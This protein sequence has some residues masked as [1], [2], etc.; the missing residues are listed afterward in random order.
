MNHILDVD[1]P[2]FDGAGRY[3]PNFLV[4]LGEIATEVRLKESEATDLDRKMALNMMEIGRLLA[5]ALD[6]FNLYNEKQM[7]EGEPKGFEE[8]LKREFKQDRSYAYKYIKFYTKYRGDVELV[9]HGPGKKALFA[10][11]ADD[12]SDEVKR[13]VADK[14]AAGVQVKASDITNLKR[15]EKGLPPTW[16]MPDGVKDDISMAYEVIMGIGDLSINPGTV[17]KRYGFANPTNKLEEFERRTWKKA[18]KRLRRVAK[19]L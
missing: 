5:K 18:I 8:W 3:P 1:R 11:A 9:P 19:V 10:L 2:K 7:G 4:E 13:D 12:V 16:R 17:A 6:G 14:V 15:A